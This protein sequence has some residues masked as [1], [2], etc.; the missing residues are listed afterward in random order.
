MERVGFTISVSVYTGLLNCKVYELGWEK[1][2]PE[3][4]GKTLMVLQ[5][6]FNMENE[7]KKQ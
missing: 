4:F 7:A 2:S 6:E 5:E 3:T 1:I